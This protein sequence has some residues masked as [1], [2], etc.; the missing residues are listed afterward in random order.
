M[1]LAELAGR[2]LAA[3]A[4]EGAGRILHTLSVD[5]RDRRLMVHPVSPYVRPPRF[6]AM[7]GGQDL[8]GAL[9]RRAERAARALREVS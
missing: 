6:V 2:L 4:D 1:P 5:L 8:P 9:G 7:V 3:I